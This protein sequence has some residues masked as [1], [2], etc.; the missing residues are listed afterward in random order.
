MPVSVW[1]DMSTVV[2]TKLV[3][4][5]MSTCSVDETGELGNMGCCL[6]GTDL[7]F[8]LVCYTQ[9]TMLSA[10]SLLSSLLASFFRH[11]LSP[12]ST[13]LLIV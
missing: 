6:A 2:S 8:A 5:Y 10:S 7:V 11:S 12:E 1:A 13:G 3:I 9:L 4:N